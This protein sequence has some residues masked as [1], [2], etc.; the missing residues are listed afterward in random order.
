MVKV[1]GNAFFY[2]DGELR[3]VYTGMSKVNGLLVGS[4]WNT[5]KFYDMQAVTKEFDGDKYTQ[6]IAKYESLINQY[7]AH[8]ANQKIRV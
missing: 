8:T 7:S 4:E 1:N 3:A 6:E 5:C 2:L